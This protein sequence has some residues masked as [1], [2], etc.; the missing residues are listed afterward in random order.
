MIQPIPTD[1]SKIF[2]NAYSTDIIRTGT[3]SDGSCFFHALFYALSSTYRG[4][5]EEQRIQLIHKVRK[6]IGNSIT[7]DKW[8]TLG[9]GEIF[10]LQMSS[11]LRDAVIHLCIKLYPDPNEQHIM[12]N[13]WDNDLLPKLVWTGDIQ[14]NFQAMLNEMFK[15]A[16]LDAKN[17]LQVVEKETFDNFIAHI[18]TD[19]VDEFGIDIASE[20]VKSNIHF[21]QAS[22]RKVYKTFSKHQYNRNVVLCWIDDA[23]YECLG[24][25][26]NGD[27]VQRVFSNNNSF[28]INLTKNE[29]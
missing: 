3:I 7:T 17:I 14:D 1:K 4:L 9:D 27:K 13:K 2:K 26:I 18:E 25:I 12:V 24:K 29:I 5:D 11:G 20:Y 15:G 10:R 6:E 19:W 21:I 23:H 16:A 8:K 22:N 28:I